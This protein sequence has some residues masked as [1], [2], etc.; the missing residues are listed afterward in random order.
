[1]FKKIIYI[2]YLLFFISCNKT[3][4]AKGTH[5][6]I[7]IISSKEDRLYA[8]NDILNFFSKKINTPYDEN[9]YEIK[10][11]DSYNNKEFLNYKNLFFLSLDVPV[12]TTVDLINSKFKNKY[13]NN[14]F[15][16]ND[17]YARNQTA[18]IFNVEDSSDMKFKLDYYKDWILDSYNKNIDKNIYRNLFYSGYN[19]EIEKIIDYKFNIKALIQ[20]DYK[21]IKNDSINNQFLWIGRGYPYRWVTFIKS[22]INSNEDLWLKYKELVNKYMKNVHIVD[23]YKNITY[24]DSVVVRFQGL[25]EEDFSDT[26]GPF[27]TKLVR[28]N[29]DDILFISG[30]VNNP[31][32]NKYLL[33]KELEVLINNFKL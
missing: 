32:K 18:L 16:I 20:L 29:N 8:Y 24:N 4:Y 21:I 1:M 27:F 28:L 5:N 23:Y 6:Q 14:I 19:L 11:I 26:G 13:E 25:Y 22:S 17:L 33:L 10:W 3:N 2:V 12:D 30:Y 15:L 9:I 31:G 7:T